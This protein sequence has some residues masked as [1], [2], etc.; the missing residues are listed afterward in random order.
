MTST[1]LSWITYSGK[2]S[3]HVT[4]IFKQPYGEELRPLEYLTT[5]WG[6]LAIL[7]KESSF[8]SNSYQE[9]DTSC[10]QL[11][12]WNIL[13]ANL[14][15]SVRSSDDCGPTQHL[16]YNLGKD[17]EPERQSSAT[18]KLLI[19]R[20]SELIKVYCFQLLTFRVICHS[21]IYN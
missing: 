9:T 4:N 12:E 14:P 13:E 17:P 18:S 21:A 11:C 19:H 6:F 2:A 15:A 16:Y 20:N 5:N 8:P 3:C 10:Q 7:N 1:L